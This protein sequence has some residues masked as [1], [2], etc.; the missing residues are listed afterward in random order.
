[1]VTGYLTL[2]GSV[3]CVWLPSDGR[4][5]AAPIGDLSGDRGATAVEYALF[6]GLIAL[7]IVA[8]MTTFGLAVQGLFD[9]PCPLSEP[10]P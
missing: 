5:A 9:V 3:P 2:Y 10:C 6:M 1:M 7:V 8:S 4:T